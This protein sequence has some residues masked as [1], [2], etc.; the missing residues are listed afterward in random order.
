MIP[1]KCN[2]TYGQISFWI[3]A[4][5]EAIIPT[6]AWI[7]IDERRG[8][9]CI[10]MASSPARC[11]FDSQG[12]SF[13]EFLSSWCS[14]VVRQRQRSAALQFC[15]N[16]GWAIPLIFREYTAPACC[17][18]HKSHCKLLIFWIR[19]LELCSLLDWGTWKL[20]WLWWS[21]ISN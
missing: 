8:F 3:S 11:L 10:H 9:G 13:R 18:S 1:E 12:A 16:Y 5:I 15:L 17:T 19:H 20:A 21:G 14:T 7:V 2:I 4:L 6:H